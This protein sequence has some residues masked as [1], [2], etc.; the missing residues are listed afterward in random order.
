M[1]CPIVYGKRR[2]D[3]RGGLEFRGCLKIDNLNNQ[4]FD[5]IASTP[6][7]YRP[8]INA[9]PREDGPAILIEKAQT[10]SKRLRGNCRA[11]SLRSTV[12]SRAESVVF[13]VDLGVPGGNYFPRISRIVSSQP[14]FKSYWGTKPSSF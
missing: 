14:A 12:A 4:P 7:L 9:T 10:D 5:G 11:D 8:V 1:L 6:T 3:G 13:Q 2:Q